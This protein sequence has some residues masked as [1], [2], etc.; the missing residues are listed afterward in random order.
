MCERAS[1]E[2]RDQERAGV[3]TQTGQTDQGNG[4]RACACSLLCRFFT[5]LIMLGSFQNSK[6]RRK[7]VPAD[8]APDPEGPVVIASRPSRSDG[9]LGSPQHLPSGARSVFMSSFSRL[10]RKYGRAFVTAPCFSLSESDSGGLLRVTHRPSRVLGT[11]G[12]RLQ[13]PSLHPEPAVPPGPGWF[14]S[15]F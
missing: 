7:A 12:P 11:G 5:T 10:L 14:S 13:T 1:V 3:G 9:E 8:G 15:G 6:L 2:W 4:M